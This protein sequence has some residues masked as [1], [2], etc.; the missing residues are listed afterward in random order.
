M[1]LEPTIL[2]LGCSVDSGRCYNRRAPLCDIDSLELGSIDE[3]NTFGF[4]PPPWRLDEAPFTESQAGEES[5]P[6]IKFRERNLN[7]DCA[8]AENGRLACIGGH[9]EQPMIVASS[10]RGEEMSNPLRSASQILVTLSRA[11]EVPAQH[12]IDGIV[13][14]WQ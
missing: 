1:T 14:R 2:S 7:A 13:T 6:Y 3:V 10:I 11:H 8:R 12:L 9:I 5:T 4:L